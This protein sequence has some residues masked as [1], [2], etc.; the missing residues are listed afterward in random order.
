MRNRCIRRSFQR[1]STGLRLQYLLRSHCLRYSGR[2]F[3]FASKQIN[4]CNEICRCG[5]M[6]DAQ[7]LKFSK[8]HFLTT[9]RDFFSHVFTLMFTGLF[10]ILA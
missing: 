10:S 9:A 4:F 6:A 8:S 5:E 1:S 2:T 3:E 7:D